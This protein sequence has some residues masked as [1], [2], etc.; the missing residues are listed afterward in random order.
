MAA[1]SG[2]WNAS[3][4]PSSGLESGVVADSVLQLEH[5]LLCPCGKFAG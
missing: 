3:P 2:L 1:T 4:L 5:Q